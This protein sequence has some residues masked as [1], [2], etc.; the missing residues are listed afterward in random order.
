MPNNEV[1]L[2]GAGPTG[3]AMAIELK[4]QGVPFRLVDKSRS[5]R[6]IRKLL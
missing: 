6:G 3:L 1:L 4:R 2:V 5:P